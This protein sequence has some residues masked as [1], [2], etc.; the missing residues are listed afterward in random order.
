[1]ESVSEGRRCWILKSLEGGMSSLN[2]DIRE[3]GKH[4]SATVS[5]LEYYYP[6]YSRD[7]RFKEDKQILIEQDKALPSDPARSN[8]GCKKSGQETG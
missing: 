7:P 8:G 6:K 4:N 3:G 1:M 5:Y 2:P